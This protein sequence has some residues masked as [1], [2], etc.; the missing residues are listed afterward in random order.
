MVDG[1]FGMRNEATRI[2][3]F[4]ELNPAATAALR[5]FCRRIGAPHL[6]DEVLMPKLEEGDTRIYA[7][8]RDR[9]W[10][11]WGLGAR[12]VIAVCQVQAI[13]DESFALSP[14]YVLDEEATNV[15][16]LAALYKEVLEELA[17]SPNAEIN[18]LVADGS[19]LANH[20][21]NGAGFKRYDDVFLTE[22]SRYFTYRIP[23]NELIV[24]LGLSEVDTVDLLAHDVPTELLAQHALFHL[25][26]NLATRAEWIARAGIPEIIDLVRGGHAS[27]P[28]GVPS[29]TNRW[30]WQERFDPV[31][32]VSL[33][34]FLGDLRNE[35]LD[36]VLG[37]EQEFQHST[38]LPPGKEKPV[39]DERLR[40]SKTIYRL[41]KFE[42]VFA[43]R[44][45]EAVEPALARLNRQGF[46]MGRVEMQVTAS[47]DGDF[48]RMHRDDDGTTTRELSFVYFFHREP[49]RFFGGELRI[50]DN[51]VV[52]GKVL[53]TDRSQTLSPRQD[54]VVFFPAH[55]EHEVLPV[56]VP[57]K[58]F[59]DS[60]FTV[61]GWIHRADT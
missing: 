6:F 19:V 47:N 15:G 28:G 61:N 26:I 8:V 33:E 9:P 32:F 38:L 16:M 1:L 40:R 4:E 2:D 13:A 30:G 49:R 35:L 46:P 43:E 58:Q 27:K 55:N 25:T 60:R 45:R 14:I 18:Y 22:Q 39:V 52:D 11:P 48:F 21:L 5:S 59:G 50:F 37:L 42:E 41:E 20:V 51:E 36:Y 17:V 23:V 3:V 29:G 53:P 56:R 12:N 24:R 44:L 57:S 7:A 31:I 54:M 10:P 34:N